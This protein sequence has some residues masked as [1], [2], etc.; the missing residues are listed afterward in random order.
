MT[1]SLSVKQTCDMFQLI[2]EKSNQ[3][4]AWSADTQYQI[5]INPNF[6]RPEIFMA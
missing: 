3:Q 2:K 1:N 4:I 6:S 5:S